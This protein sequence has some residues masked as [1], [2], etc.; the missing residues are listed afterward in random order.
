MSLR[1]IVAVAAATA[2]TLVAGV[3]PAILAVA[4]VFHPRRLS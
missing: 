2:K 1:A 4:A 3:S